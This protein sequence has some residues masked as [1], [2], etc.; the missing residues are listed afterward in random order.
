MGK[1]TLVELRVEAALPE[2]RIVSALFHNVPI[3]HHKNH[4]R[5]PDRGQPMGD[6]EGGTSFHHGVERLL[7]P[8]L[9]PGIDGGGRLIQKQHGRKAQHHSGDTQQL[10]LS[11][12]K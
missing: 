7:D 9:C 11:L 12:G 2:K 5:F 4:I 8:D 1:L 10:L 6:N 3:P